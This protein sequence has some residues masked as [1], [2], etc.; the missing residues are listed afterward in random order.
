MLAAG[1]LEWRGA[2]PCTG[3]IPYDAIA[4]EFGHYNIRTRT[5]EISAPAPLF[6]RL[7][8]NAYDALPPVIRQ[9]HEVHGVLVLEGKAD[10]AR[11]DNALGILIAWL[12]RLPQ[13]GSDMTVRVE[14]RS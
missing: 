5:Q 9:A 1:R 2:G 11:P 3:L 12:F 7:L 14:M 4:A 10:V 6:R 8:G 13:S